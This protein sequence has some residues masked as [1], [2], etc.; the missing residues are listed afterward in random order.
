VSNLIDSSVQTSIETLLTEFCWRVD[1]W[2]GERIAELFTADA[3]IDTPHFNLAGREQIHDWFAARANKAGNRLSRHFWTNL[4]ITSEG[5]NR[6]L[7]QANAMTLVGTQPTPCLSTRIA[8]GMSTDRI[9]VDDGK[10][11]FASRTLSVA[12]EGALAV[13]EVHP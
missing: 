3:T 10:V 2:E 4:R 12:F 13:S 6:Y 5:N 1:N 7:A 8:A 9:V 11:L